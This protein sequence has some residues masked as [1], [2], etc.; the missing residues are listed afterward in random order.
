M[1]VRSIRKN[2]F[3]PIYAYRT[4]DRTHVTRGASSRARSR[5]EPRIGDDETD[6]NT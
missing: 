3:A 2:R 6:V 4:N 1:I 5:D